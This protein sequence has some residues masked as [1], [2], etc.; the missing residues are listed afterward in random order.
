MQPRLQLF[1]ISAAQ[2]G[3]SEWE[4]RRATTD[5]G[6]EE[7]GGGGERAGLREFVGSLVYSVVVLTSGW[8]PAD[9]GLCLLALVDVKEL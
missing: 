3:N 8:T 4:R 7:G 5:S 9:T 2:R 1:F 6:K